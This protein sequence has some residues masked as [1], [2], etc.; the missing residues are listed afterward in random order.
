MERIVWVNIGIY[1][2]MN[3]GVFTIVLNEYGGKVN[4]YV[5]ELG[6]LSRKNK[7]LGV[8]LSLLLISLIGVRRLAGFY[9]KYIIVENMVYSGRIVIGMVS[10]LSSVVAIYYY[11]R[12]VKWIY[13]E[14]GSSYGYKMLRDV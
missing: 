3:I 5:M 4:N 10:V 9:S 1:I 2:I 14:E 13:V 11:V 12:V 6:G 8:S 7:V